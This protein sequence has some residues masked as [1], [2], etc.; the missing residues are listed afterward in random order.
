MYF[1]FWLHFVTL[2]SY[3]PVVVSGGFSLLCR[4]GFTFGGWGLLSSCGVWGSPCGGFSCCR[5]PALGLLGFSSWAHGLNSCG[6]QAQLLC[7]LWDPPGPGIEPLLPV[8]AGGFLTPEP[9]G[10][11]NMRIFEIFPPHSNRQPS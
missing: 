11:P 6:A 5:A 4:V 3:S 7:G 10:K 2:L 9:P 8:L 1:Y